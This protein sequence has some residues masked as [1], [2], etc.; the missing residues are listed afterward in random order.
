[1]DFSARPEICLPLLAVSNRGTSVIMGI[2]VGGTTTA[3]GL[4][5]ADGEVRFA[6]ERPTHG[7]GP[8]TAVKTLLGLVEEVAA[9]AERRQL[10]VEAVGLGLPGVI[11]RASG[12]M[13]AAPGN[14]V[15][16]FVGVPIGDEIREIA[17]A[18]VVVENDANALALGA[19]TFGPGRGADSLVL[20]AIGT[21]IGGGIIRDGELLRGAHGSA[22]EFHALVVNYEGERCH[23]CGVRGC[24][25][26]YVGGRA[27]AEEARRR[28]AAGA[29]SC[30]LDLVG[31]AVEAVRSEDV[32]RAAAAGDAMA[33]AI[34]R[35]ACVALGAAITS[36]VGSLDPDV[37]VVTGGVARSLVALAEE[38]HRATGHSG[39]SP[40]LTKARIH[41]VDA[42]K[43]QTVLGA[44][45]AVLHERARR[46]RGRDGKD[47]EHVR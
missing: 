24:L 23:L 32:F 7:N 4:V 9:E 21:E 11:D 16:E 47:G 18:P 43:T 25:G 5:T 39:L 2:D 14:R 10:A 35:R 29:P 46:A 15:P 20:L 36:I 19:W 33:V 37:V 41:I 26:L 45:A 31:G 30:L 34:V 6:A 12:T 42:T 1:M 40:V 17:R 38:I 22:G 13:L 8:G 3:A 28:L 27:I 44:A